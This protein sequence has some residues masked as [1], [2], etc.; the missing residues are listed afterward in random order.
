MLKQ[1]KVLIADDHSVVR[2]GLKALISTEPDLEVVGEA[3][4]GQKAVELA[5]KLKPDVVIMDAIMPVVNGIMATRRIARLLPKSRILVL[6]ASSDEE[7]AQQMCAAGA[8]G[9]VNKQSAPAHLLQ[10]IREVWQGTAWFSPHSANKVPSAG[11]TAPNGQLR[12]L[13]LTARETQVLRL[14]AEG[15]SNKMIAADLRIT[16]ATVRTHRQQLM[17]K[18]KIHGVARLT[19]Y[20]MANRLIADA[21][22][23]W[24]GNPRT[25]GVAAAA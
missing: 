18:L 25:N 8:A 2:E 17:D 10:G 23:P 20:A 13:R 15:L 22:G 9:Y 1:I 4:D 3:E 11:N 16:L 21:S 12:N 19:R 5:K 24:L 14:V 7:L 6:S